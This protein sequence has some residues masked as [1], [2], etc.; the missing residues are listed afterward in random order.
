MTIAGLAERHRGTNA[1]IPAQW[2]RFARH[3][4]TIPGRVGRTAYGVV[5]DALEGMN[6]GYLAG[7]EISDPDQLPQ[8][9]GHLDIPAQRYAV[10]DHRDHVLQLP[11]T[12][13]A[14]FAW[15]ASSHH[16]HAG[17]GADLIERYGED[18]DPRNG[19]GRIEIWL[20][21]KG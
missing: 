9:F 13:G 7:V 1:G 10:F 8:E 18:F 12:V 17:D 2:Q 21:I 4:G 6:F 19:A 14:A 5:F 11:H 20:P 15:L 3:I 16:E